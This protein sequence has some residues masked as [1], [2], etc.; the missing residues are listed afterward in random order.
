MLLEVTTSWGSVRLCLCVKEII[1]LLKLLIWRQEYVGDDFI[2]QSLN[3]LRIYDKLALFAF[4]GLD[5][6]EHWQL[7]KLKKMFQ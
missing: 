5:I 7:F 1:F 6:I 2:F 3:G 4:A